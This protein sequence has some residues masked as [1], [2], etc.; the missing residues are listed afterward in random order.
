MQPLSTEE[1][2]AL[3]LIPRRQARELIGLSRPAFDRLE[4]RGELPPAVRVSPGRRAYRL[5]DLEA[6]IDSRTAKPEP[7]VEVP[8]V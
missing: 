6:W 2:A 4:R 7:D 3:R 8:L 5:R 1:I